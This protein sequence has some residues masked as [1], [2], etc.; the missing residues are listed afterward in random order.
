[1]FEGEYS[2]RLKNRKGKEYISEKL[3]FEGEYFDNK[4]WKGNKYDYNVNIIEYISK[5][6]NGKGKEYNKY[7]KLIFEG[8]YI[9]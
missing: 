2:N 6:K 7:G 9:N 1:M 5:L 8:E 3:E 4:R